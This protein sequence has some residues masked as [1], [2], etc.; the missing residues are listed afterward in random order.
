MFLAVFS[1]PVGNKINNIKL[2]E[3]LFRQRECRMGILFIEQRYQ[4]A[5]FA[6]L[7]APGT[8]HLNGRA[9]NQPVAGESELRSPRFK[10]T[11]R[12]KLFVRDVWDPGFKM[13]F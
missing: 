9:L 8:F 13:V 3:S 11:I 6:D 2:S 1:N 4:E 5:A 7:I 10:A 12:R